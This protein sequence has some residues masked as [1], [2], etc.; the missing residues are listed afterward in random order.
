VR[1]LVAEKIDPCDYDGHDP[2]L[3]AT[4][5]PPIRA[6]TS[7][8]VAPNETWRIFFL[9]C[10][11]EVGQGETW[12]EDVFSSTLKAIAQ[13]E[14]A[15]IPYRMLCRSIFDTDPAAMYLALYRCIGSLYAYTSAQKIITSLGI[16]RDWPDVAVVLEDQLGWY[17][18]EES[19]L[20]ELLSMAVPTDLEAI[21]RALGIQVSEGTANL[22]ASAAR[23]IYKLRNDL[24]HFRPTHHRVD[25]S[26]LQWNQLCTALATLVF[27]I[28]AEVFS[29]R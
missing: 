20:A 5:F 12:I 29:A 25:F 7:V 10:V 9:L 17:P 27:H 28:Y 11:I 14:L 4:L 26:E 2:G 16:A 1:H 8:D 15:N 24:V 23:A 3:V 22:G 21:F 19:S 18:K 6:F 13:L